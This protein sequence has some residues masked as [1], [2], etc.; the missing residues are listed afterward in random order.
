[1][2]DVTEHK[3]RRSSAW[4][5][6][7]RKA[8]RARKPPRILFIGEGAS[9]AHTVRP[10]TLARELG[11]RD[12]EV[13]FACDPIYRKFVKEQQLEVI[14][15]GLGHGSGPR[16][17]RVVS[18]NWRNVM[19]YFGILLHMM[20][21]NV[22]KG[23]QGGRSRDQ[24]LPISC[25]PSQVFQKRASQGKPLYTLE[26]LQSYL[27]DDL[28]MIS[29]VSPDVVVGDFRLSLSTA[30]ELLGVPTI[31]LGNV[32]WS[33]NAGLPSPL[34]DL[35]IVKLLCV[36]ISRPI[37]RIAFE[38][39]LNLQVNTINTI[40]RP[41][42]LAPIKTG[43]ELYTGGTKTLYLDL[44]ELFDLSTLADHE[45]FIGPVCWE[46]CGQLPEWWGRLPEGRPL[47]Y[48]SPGSTG[49]LGSVRTILI[50]LEEMDVSVIVATAG[51]FVPSSES[52]GL[53]SAPFIPG[54]AACERADLMI[55]NG[56]ATIYQP[57]A[58]GTPVLGIPINADQYY[59]SE[60]L[61]RRG[62]G[63]LVR[64]GKATKRRVTESVRALLDDPTY[65]LEARRLQ[66]HIAERT[67][68]EGI[69]RIIDQLLLS[70]VSSIPQT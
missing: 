38:T 51:R 41:L 29:T 48:F 53:F 27:R 68:W 25:V 3:E 16:P 36:T 32:H 26:E 69:R 30:G 45:D 50:A 21:V 33:P 62:A 58:T 4:F 55:C 8:P 59:I 13:F 1:M 70:P 22:G 6:T 63:K 19:K 43:R 42:G 40:R 64:S 11:E 18:T 61:V 9:L 5:T 7:S 34:P 20:G 57:L 23:S 28:R 66:M 60:A 37:V 31:A 56:G 44:P 24:G 2:G 46:P 47:V 49:D 12:C 17:W 35:P 15:I 65:T 54:M 67:P 14:P 52:S 39:V 10:L